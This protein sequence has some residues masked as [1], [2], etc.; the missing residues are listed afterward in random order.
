MITQEF[1]IAKVWVHIINTHYYVSNIKI[2]SINTN[3]MTVGTQL[4]LV[5]FEVNDEATEASASDKE[6]P[7][8][9]Q[10]RA[11]QSLAPSPHIPT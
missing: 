4:I 3:R 8:C 2:L 7:A 9:A 5:V 6:I 1:W 11:P 10:R